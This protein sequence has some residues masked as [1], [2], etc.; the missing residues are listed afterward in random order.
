MGRVQEIRESIDRHPLRSRLLSA[1]VGLP[2]VGGAVWLGSFWLSALVAFAAGVGAWELCRMARVGGMAPAAGVAV[3]W[4]LVLVALAHVAATELDG[5]F[6]RQA[7]VALVVLAYLLWQ[8]R[9]V[10]VRLAGA[11]WAVTAG[12]ALYT[13]GLLAH[14]VLLRSL[15]DGRWWLLCAVLVTF[16]AD[17]A[18]YGAGRLAG[19]TRLAPTISPG[20][21][22]EGAVS[23]VIGAIAAALLAVAVLDVEV[24]VYQVIAFGTLLGT[25]GQLGDLLESWAKRAAG[26]KDSGW[27]IPGHGGVLDRLDSIVPNVAVMYYFVI[28]IVQ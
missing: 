27:L 21:T 17:T 10:R 1:A 2:I 23:G 11:D 8:V 25:T 16:A 15:D 6:G 24:A 26:V 13:G 19:R 5:D 4:S 20:K 9:R 14:A 28:G 12:A 22:W 7:L 18:A 3:G